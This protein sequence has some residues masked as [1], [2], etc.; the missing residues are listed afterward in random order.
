MAGTFL[1]HIERQRSRAATQTTRPT[2]KPIAEMSSKELDAALVEA[3]REAVEANRAVAAVA[4][5]EHTRPPTLAAT[6]REKKRGKR[7]HWR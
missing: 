6:L 2:E 5:E 1:A 3:K 7:K 4:A